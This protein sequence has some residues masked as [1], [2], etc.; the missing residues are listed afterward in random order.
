MSIYT[1]TKSFNEFF[2][3]TENKK[4]QKYQITNEAIK[5]YEFLQK[6]I[7]WLISSITNHKK[8]ALQGV[9][10]D[11]ENLLKDMLGWSETKKDNF[12][13]T[14]I[15]AMVRFLVSEHGFIVLNN[16][17]S[18]RNNEIISTASTYTN[19]N[20]NLLTNS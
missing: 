6:R 19:N 1:S 13:I 14:M 15:G 20:I 8:P 16:G 4:Y 11:L 2:E 5:V 18:L 12:F 9:I 7:D 3:Q 17:I 10:V